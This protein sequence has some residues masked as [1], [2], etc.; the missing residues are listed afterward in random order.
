MSTKTPCYPLFEMFRYV[1]A[2]GIP[3]KVGCTPGEPYPD[4]EA[5]LVPVPSRVLKKLRALA[6]GEYVVEKKDGEHRVIRRVTRIE[7]TVIA[8][9]YTDAGE[10]ED[11][12]AALERM[13]AGR[14]TKKGGKR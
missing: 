12:R 6:D 1:D 2:S 3:S 8:D 4:E 11:A 9:G 7:E 5:V 14:P 10:A 13:K